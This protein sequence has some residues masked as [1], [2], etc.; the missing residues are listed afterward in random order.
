MNVAIIVSTQ[1]QAGMN[2]KECLIE[3]GRF[4]SL[5]FKFHNHLVYEFK[6][7]LNVV[8][9]FTTDNDSISCEHIDS[10][11]KQSGFDVDKIIFATKHQSEAGV[12]SLCVH[13]PGNW[14]GAAAGGRSRFL[15]NS[16][17]RMMKQALL[18]LKELSAETDYEVMQE[19][20]HHGPEI[21]TPCLF[22]EIGSSNDS[23]INKLAGKILAD[24]II[25]L[26]ETN[27]PEF[28][29]VIVLGGGHYSQPAEKLVFRTDYAVGHICPKYALDK[30]DYLG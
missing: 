4:E 24:T 11:I 10:E 26:L 9:F 19:V 13:V 17:P 16:M 21:N 25:Y 23:W 22:I 1:D 15:C 2:I 28:E 7:E 12:H 27:P 8:R 30:L 6:T 14:G 20:T 18:K 3:T 29:C 5:D